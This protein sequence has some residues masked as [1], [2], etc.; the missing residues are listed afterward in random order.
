VEHKVSQ[1]DG[2]ISVKPD[3]IG[4]RGG[5]E[6]EL[7]LETSPDVDVPSKT[8]EICQV[9]KEAVEDKMGLKLRKVRA[10]IKHT[11]FSVGPQVAPRQPAPYPTPELIIPEETPP[12]TEE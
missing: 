11:P 7:D 8:E 4:R 2:V 10:N 12:L 5:V 6:V 3:I 9:V 1:L